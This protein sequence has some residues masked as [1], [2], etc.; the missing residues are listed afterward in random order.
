MYRTQPDTTRLKFRIMRAGS[1]KP[2][3]EVEQHVATG[4]G[5]NPVA[6]ALM[7]QGLPPG[8]Y[9]LSVNAKNGSGE[10]ERSTAFTMASFET[11]PPAS[12]AAGL[13]AG[14]GPSEQSLYD[15]YFAP[16]AASDAEVSNLLE[17]MTVGAPGEYVS[18]DN[19]TLTIDAK[20]RF[21]A[22]YWS[23]LRDPNPATP[24][25]EM[26]D[27]YTARVRYVDREFREKQGGRSGTKTDRGRIYL[28]WGAP[29]VVQLVQIPSNNKTVLLWKYTRAR[30]FKYAF[31]DE[32]GFEQYNLIYTTDP[33]ERTLHDWQDR[34]E[35]PD[36][37]QQITS[38]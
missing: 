36:T 4:A 35:D 38:F 8:D 24:A 33:R 17:A 22:R 16:A 5:V 32:R 11:A 15:R 23:K 14:G 25:H 21:L 12:S 37:I 2:V 7:V 20:R 27:E 3:T 26:L 6:A 30:P 34:V 10:E 18:A 31:L 13:P 29:D 9:I 19:L 28:R 1:D